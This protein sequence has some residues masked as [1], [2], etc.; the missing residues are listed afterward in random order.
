M[1]ATV[2]RWRNQSNGSESNRFAASVALN[3]PSMLKL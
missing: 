1:Y 3:H 2:S